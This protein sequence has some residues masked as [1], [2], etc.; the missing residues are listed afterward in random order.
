MSFEKKKIQ[1]ETLSEYLSAIRSGHGLSVE[2]AAGQTG[3]R[4]EFLRA[5]EAGEFNAL[6]PDVYVFGFLRQLAELYAVD[7]L[8]LISQ[9]KK[10]KAIANQMQR[11]TAVRKSWA[12]R[13]F[14]KLVITPKVLSITVGS[15]FV[16]LTL[17]YIVWQVLSINKTP[18]LE[19][20]QPRDGQIIKDSFVNVRGQTDSGSSVTVNGQSVFVDSGGN[21]Q[22]QL[23]LKPGPE[24]INIVA[25]NKMG[26]T[27]AAKMSVIGQADLPSSPNQVSLKLE[28]S[29]DGS[30]TYAIDNSPSQQISFHAG[31]VKTLT[32]QN[33]IV[34]STSNAG[35]TAATLNGQ[36]LGPLGRRGEQLSDIPFTAENT[37]T[38][39]A[40]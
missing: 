2:T 4:L 6:P 12:G 13:H 39:S 5:L 34:I 22:T 30:L 3:I 21:F 11:S 10:E 35:A 20:F 31:D 9:Y 1:A 15:L 23:S 17:L 26:K 40:P 8:A 29:A 32:G 7:G 28:F 19:I 14:G 38:S 33:K 25:D 27:A 37:A 36:R 24:E 18:S 16:A